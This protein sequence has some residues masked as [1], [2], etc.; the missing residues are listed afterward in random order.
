[1]DQNEAGSL[2]TPRAEFT[3]VSGRKEEVN[4]K[5]AEAQ[6]YLLH[7]GGEGLLSRWK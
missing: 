3:K 6:V 2:R 5:A 4:A 7:T 1:M